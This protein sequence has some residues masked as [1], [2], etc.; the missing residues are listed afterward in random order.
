MAV[1]SLHESEDEHGLAHF[2]EHMAFRG[3]RTHPDGSH[4]TALQRLGLGF[5]PDSTAFT[6]YDHTIYHLEL[7]APKEATLRE[8]LRIFRD[9]AEEVTFDPA[10]IER[11]RGV[12]LSE[13][14]T[15]NTPKPA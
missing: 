4:V 10:L 5:G 2:V 8:G 12:I 7:P 6:S 3:T 9:Y 14:S 1:G 11:E 15:R 13:K